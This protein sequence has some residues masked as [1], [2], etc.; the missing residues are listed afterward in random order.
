[1]LPVN[2]VLKVVEEL[3]KPISLSLRLFGNLYA[4]ELIFILIASIALVCPV[5]IGWGMGYIPHTYY[6]AASIY[7]YD[8]DHRI[9]QYGTVRSLTTIGEKTML[10]STL[11]VIGQLEGMTVIAAALLIGLGALGTAIGF[12]LLGGKFLGVLHANLKWQPCCRLK[13]SLWLRFWMR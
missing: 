10:Q 5:D 9:H 1:M 6:C 8:A 7:F 2:L 4:G 3:A 13:C 11:T 12:G